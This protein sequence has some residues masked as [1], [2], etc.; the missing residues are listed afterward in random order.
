MEPDLLAL[1]K[2]ASIPT[3]VHG[4][5]QLRAYQLVVRADAALHDDR[6][7]EAASL[8]EQALALD[9][10]SD[11]AHDDLGDALMY[12][13]NWDQGIASYEA[14]EG[15]FHLNWA[16]QLK[17]SAVKDSHTLPAWLAVHHADVALADKRWTDAISAAH[18]AIA[19]E[20]SWSQPYLRVGQAEQEQSHW[21]AAINAFERAVALDHNNAYANEVL[22][23]AKS[24][25]KAA[26]RA[27]AKSVNKQ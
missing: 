22:T 24:A 17:K 16:K 13:G 11:R 14:V 7:P 26:K 8:A 18:Q 3:S 5:P 19:L 23:A 20:P 9:P 12:Q 1:A 4:L 27:D 21:E 10:D 2:A 15:D 25:Y 6:F